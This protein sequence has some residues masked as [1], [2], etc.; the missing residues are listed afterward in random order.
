MAH[1]TPSGTRI[2]WFSD[3][4]LKLSTIFSA[5]IRNLQYGYYN[6]GL[7]YSHL[8]N[9]HEVL[10]TL[11]MSYVNYIIIITI[12]WVGLWFVVVHIFPSYCNLCFWFI[13]MYAMTHAL[14]FPL[15]LVIYFFTW[16]D[17]W[18]YAGRNDH[19]FRIQNI[20][21]EFQWKGEYVVLHEWFTSGCF[22]SKDAYQHIW[23][24]LLTHI[25]WMHIKHFLLKSRHV[26]KMLVCWPYQIHPSSIAC[27]YKVG[28]YNLLLSPDFTSRKTTNIPD[29]NCDRLIC[30]FPWVKLSHASSLYTSC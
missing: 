27:K 20:N 7:P 17:C 16:G 19:L 24:V 3:C 6:N 1:E 14:I 29:I 13:Q 4:M 5:T 30:Y 8:H 12:L 28:K 11:E 9:T 23:N 21:T 2:L 15:S 25:E 22:K 10:W 18:I 26:T